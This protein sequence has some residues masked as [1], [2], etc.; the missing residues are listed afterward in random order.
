MLYIKEEDKVKKIS[1]CFYV[2]SDK[3]KQLRQLHRLYFVKDT[4]LR[5]INITENWF[6][7][8]REGDTYGAG[9]IVLEGRGILFDKPGGDYTFTI[10]ENIRTIHMVA[11]GA[12]GSGGRNDG[13]GFGGGGGG[14]A[15]VINQSVT[16]QER[17]TITV[18]RGGNALTGDVTGKGSDGEK[19]SI[20]NYIKAEGGGGG[21]IYKSGK[22]GGTGG[23][24]EI[25]KDRAT[26]TAAV[27]GTGGNGGSQTDGGGGGGAAGYGGSGGHGGGQEASQSGQQ[28]G[29]G[30]GGSG[31]NSNHSEGVGGMGGG[32]SPFGKGADGDAGL[33]NETIDGEPGI[34]GSIKTSY[35]DKCYGGGSGGA[36]YPSSTVAAQNGAV[37][38]CW[39]EPLPIT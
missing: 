34:G 15:A 14:L 26:H 6:I 35:Q 7:L 25:I 1:R 30:G 2:T 10:P 11:I 24:G 31:S 32:V 36:D 4:Q 20:K 3:S 29:G 17:L 39:G 38:I 18:G 37:L 27:I 33:S 28:G 9:I 5:K 19:S 12:G 22:G 13:Q 23:Q 16:Q 8:G 21:D